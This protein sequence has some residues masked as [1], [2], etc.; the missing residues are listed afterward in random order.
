M[1]TLT[2]HKDEVH[3]VK[4][5]ENIFLSGSEDKCC[6][7]FLLSSASIRVWDLASYE[8]LL[9]VENAHS[10]GIFA[11]QS[12]APDTLISGGRDRVVYVL[13]FAIKVWNTADKWSLQKSLLPP[14]YDGVTSFAVSRKLAK[15][16][17]VLWFF[18]MKHM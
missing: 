4:V 13:F 11:L 10:S 16:Y 12:L 15:L 5:L 1:K 6:D 9:V 18:E 7:H 8:A 17:S 3:C 14:H 2:A